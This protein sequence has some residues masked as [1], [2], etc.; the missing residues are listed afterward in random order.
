[1]PRTIKYGRPLKDFV[2]T[3]PADVAYIEEGD[4][5]LPPALFLHGVT[6]NAA[7][8]QKVVKQISDRVRCIAI[9]IPGLG[10]TEVS[11]FEDFTMPAVAELVVELL[12]RLGLN[13]TTIVAHDHGGAI[14]QIMAATAPSR[15]RNLVL[16]DTVSHDHWPIPLQRQALRIARIPGTAELLRAGRL[17]ERSRTAWRVATGPLGFAR[18]YYN[19]DVIDA[20]LI[21]EYLRPY[22]SEDGRQRARRFLLAADSRST[23]E[24]LPRLRAYEGE[25][26]V[27]WGADDKFLS[28]SWGIQL[29]EEV[30]NGRFHLLPFCGHFAPDERPELVGRHVVEVVEG[31]RNADAPIPMAG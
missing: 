16:V 3:G 10:D 14:A 24:I 5:A 31:R 11:P 18:G 17:I 15:V 1:M 13:E 6:T 7:L 8:W 4:A 30:T 12:D 25:C 26:R 27:L 9:D 20:D 22:T 28:P 29:A 2:R 21:R 19:P 23:V